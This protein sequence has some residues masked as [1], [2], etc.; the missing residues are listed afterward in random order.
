MYVAEDRSRRSQSRGSLG[1]QRD[2]RAAESRYDS[3]LE[4]RLDPR[5]IDARHR[6]IDH[7]HDRPGPNIPPLHD[8][9][10]PPDRDAGYFRGAERS[11]PYDRV[12]IDHV[13]ISRPPPPLP[14]RGPWPPEP[15]RFPSRGSSDRLDDYH[16]DVDRHD[17]GAGHHGLP[18]PPNWERLDRS[19]RDEWET[20]FSHEQTERRGAREEV[21]EPLPAPPPVRGEVARVKTDEPTTADNP[22]DTPAPP[23]GNQFMFCFHHGCRVLR[24][25]G[26][27]IPGLENLGLWTPSRV[28]QRQQGTLGLRSR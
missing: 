9:D 1:G 16:R 13:D 8:R 26:P 20:R 10:M 27:L 15:D 6:D 19:S 28:Q 22:L 7:P 17:R 23:T 5:S 24:F 25:C 2:P 18:R 12:R 14:F 3:R 4:Y 21:R 11:L